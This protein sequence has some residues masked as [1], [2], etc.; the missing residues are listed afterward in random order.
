MLQPLNL[1]QKFFKSTV[2]RRKEKRKRKNRTKKK[3]KKN[4]IKTIK[5]KT[6]ENDQKSLLLEAKNLRKRSQSRRR[7]LFEVSQPGATR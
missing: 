6:I 7:F 5:M 4:R 3:F 1:N 2:I